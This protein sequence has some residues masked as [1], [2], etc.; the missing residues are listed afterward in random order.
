MGS[1]PK[2]SPSGGCCQTF[3]GGKS[4]GLGVDVGSQREK[5]AAKGTEFRQQYRGIVACIDTKYIILRPT[6]A[7]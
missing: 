2:L 7:K 4:V 3:L 6:I 5:A 1:L